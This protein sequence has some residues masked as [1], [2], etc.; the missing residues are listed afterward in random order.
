M[1]LQRLKTRS[2]VL[3]THFDNLFSELL[4]SGL[5]FTPS[6]HVTSNSSKS[7]NSRDWSFLGSD[8]KLEKEG[9]ECPADWE[10]NN[11]E[12]RYFLLS[13][14]INGVIDT[15][16]MLSFVWRCF[17]PRTLVNKAPQMRASERSQGL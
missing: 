16:P 13:L 7:F 3:S 11:K 15:E 6:R 14:V 12:P 9:Q 10:R 2:D 4:Q 17:L 8:N 5:W 1:Q